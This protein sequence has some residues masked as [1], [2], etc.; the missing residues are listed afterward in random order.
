MG[1]GTGILRSSVVG[2]DGKWEG[3]GKGRGGN[4]RS[5]VVG[6][7][8]KSGRDAD[9]TDERSVGLDLAPLGG[10]KPMIPRAGV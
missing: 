10:I 9:G 2:Q 4:L 5:S 8:E 6:R 3:T 1:N 7:D